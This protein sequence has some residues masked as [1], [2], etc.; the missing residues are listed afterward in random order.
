MILWR[1]IKY[2]LGYGLLWVILNFAGISLL[3]F[4]LVVLGLECVMAIINAIREGKVSW[5]E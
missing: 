2:T 4:F 5:I 3:G 1:L